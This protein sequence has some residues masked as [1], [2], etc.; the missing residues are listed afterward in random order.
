MN[1]LDWSNAG[2]KGL[3]LFNATKCCQSLNGKPLKC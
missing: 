1:L 2:G 3:M